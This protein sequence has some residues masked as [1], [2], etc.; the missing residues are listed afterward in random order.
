MHVVIAPDSFKGSLTA[1]EVGA[2]IEEAFLAAIPEV[3]TCVIPMA[4]GGEGTMRALMASNGSWEEEIEA[5]GP[6]GNR[7]KT[8]VGFLDKG[9]TAVV[10]VAEIIGLP[11]VP[12]E[13][14]NPMKTT[15]CGIGEMIRYA[16]NKGCR[17]IIVG[18]GGSATNDGGLGMLHAL[19]VR[20]IRNRRHQRSRRIDGFRYEWFER[21]IVGCGLGYYGGG[22][23]IRRRFAGRFRFMLR[24]E[25]RRVESRRCSSREDSE[26][27]MNRYMNIS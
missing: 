9:R 7:R 13:Q 2:A 1:A 15:S 11:Q 16:L 4:D 8:R 14:R 26:K 24:N 17:K 23:A 3:T 22:T 20:F 5:T 6:Y 27:V 25:P 21:R 18:L 12:L 10:E 19:G